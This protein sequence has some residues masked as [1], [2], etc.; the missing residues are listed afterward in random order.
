MATLSEIRAKYP[1]YGDLSD[2]QLA[3]AMHRKF[4]SDMPFADFSQKVGLRDAL[5]KREQV[6]VGADTTRAER[7]AIGAGRGALDAW[8]GI[9]QLVG[10]AMTGDNPAASAIPGVGAV[11]SLL[12]LTGQTES[13]RKGVEQMNAAAGENLAVYERNNPGGFATAGRII[14]NVGAVPI[15]AIAAET[16]AGRVGVG[17]LQGAAQGGIQFV[18]DGGSRAQNAAIGAVTGGLGQAVIGEP[19]RALGG[20]IAALLAPG[21]ANITKE[22]QAALDYAKQNNLPL[23]YDD[24]SGGS[25]SKALGTATDEIPVV[26]TGGSRAS[27][28]QAAES[29]ARRVVDQFQTGSGKRTADAIRESAQAQLDRAR[30][31][32]NRLYRDA[33]AELN[34]AGDLDAPRMRATA[35]RLIAEETKR[36]SLAD[37]SMISQLQ[38]FVD[39]PKFNFEGWH[40][41][42]AQLGE[43]IKRQASGDKAV[44]GDR[45][46]AM[47]RTLKGALDSDMTAM[48]SAS[49][50]RGGSLWA[51]ADDF[52]RRVMPKY[53][54]GVVADLLKSS[55]PDAIAERILGGS[56]REGMAREIFRALDNKGRAEVKGAMMAKALDG[57]I[58]T[59]RPF[60]PARFASELE[61]M[62]SR[63]DV[64]FGPRERRMLTGLQNYMEH[65]KRAGQY[66]E[67]P[68]TGKRLVPYV[69]G[70][71][72]VAEPTTGVAIGGVATM[73][74]ALFRTERGRDMMLRLGSTSPQSKGFQAL[75]QR[76]NDYATR[77]GAAEAPRQA[78][79]AARR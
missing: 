5:T 39:S 33:F 47:M 4:Y 62:G 34:K 28:A 49:G 55:N 50:G 52:Y 18:P 1:Q 44:L 78:Q 54:R 42:R 63:V 2:E 79:P 71:A 9:G 58:S 41:A 66:M 35:Q 51:R 6:D 24:V 13:A 69:V 17:A 31:I 3:V 77:A 60:S 14:G 57:A 15:P 29:E 45:A 53:K 23:H 75:I 74:K 22:A 11:R 8:Q 56:D 64:F 43:L 25:F 65:I 61:K 36:G 40:G 70:G 26:G 38:Q 10:E 46:V 19:L 67:N 21:H 59:D 27:Q 12:D 68:P 30:E 37:T 72:V 48:A 7:L 16:M 73:A 32:K 20:K 76:M